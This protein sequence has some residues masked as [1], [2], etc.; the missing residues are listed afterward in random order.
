MMNARKL[1]WKEYARGY[2]WR[3]CV[4]ALAKRS[5]GGPRRDVPDR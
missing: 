5:G 1:D 3:L 4:S 2:I